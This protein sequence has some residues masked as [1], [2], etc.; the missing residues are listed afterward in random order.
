MTYIIT[1]ATFYSS[2]YRQEKKYNMMVFLNTYILFAKLIFYYKL[3]NRLFLMF[4]ILHTK[5]RKEKK[6]VKENK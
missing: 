6:T 1:Q 5:K 4:F 2:C 3:C